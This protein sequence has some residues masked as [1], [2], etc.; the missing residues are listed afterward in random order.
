[1]EIVVNWTVVTAASVVLAFILNQALKWA[2]LELSEGIRKGIVFAV[3]V[4]LSAY[5]AYAGGFELPDVA[6][7]PFAYALA[8][9]SLATASFKAAQKVY[10]VLWQGLLK[11]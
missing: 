11:A 2:G 3:A 9:L 8:L 4:G 7:D 6:V 5:S 1:M 10:D